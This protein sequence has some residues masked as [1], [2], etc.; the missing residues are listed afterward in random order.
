MPHLLDATMF[1]TAS[2]G[3]VRRYLEAK[4]RF[5]ASTRWR[6]TVA[7]PMLDG[8]SSVRIPAALLPASG[9]YR[10]P[11][12]RAAAARV[13]AEQAPDLIE[14]GDAYRLA[15]SVLDVGQAL[16]IPALAF[17]HSNLPLLASSLLGERIGPRA[18]RAARRYACRLYRQFDL[19]LAP[20][21]TMCDHLVDWGVKRVLHQPLG[22]DSAVFHPCRRDPEW[23]RRI[24]LPAD[25][26]VLIY[27]G[28]FAPEKNLPVLTAAVR[29][30]GPPY[31]LVA[32][33]AGPTPPQGDR[34]MVLA[35]ERRPEAL[36]TLV[37][38]ADAFVHAGDQETFGLSALEALACGTPVVARAAEGLAELVDE[39]VGIAVGRTRPEDFA[40]A[41]A[42]VFDAADRERFA[43][44][45]RARGEAHDWQQTLP[46]LWRQYDRLLN[47]YAAAERLPPS[48]TRPAEAR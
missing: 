16:G 18:E 35:P 44:A 25:A 36:A 42:A 41:I 24:G 12:R 45:A 29:L 20:S 17:C 27:A 9:G 6:H 3:G 19:V 30:L 43:K 10:L 48:S 5:A 37:A 39:R 11:W 13:L 38:S 1:W 14:A 22:V 40:E 32:V 15:W 28:R 46:R 21:A 47:R 23:R 7:T 31:W 26:R 8:I 4:H 2:G 34:V 33:G